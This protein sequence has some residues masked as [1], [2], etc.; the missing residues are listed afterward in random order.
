MD[1]SLML[2]GIDKEE[3]A[4]TVMVHVHPSPRTKNR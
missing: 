3:E 2:K 1:A 4:M